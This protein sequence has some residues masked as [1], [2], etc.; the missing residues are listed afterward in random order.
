MKN[1]DPSIFNT[2]DRSLYRIGTDNKYLSENSPLDP[3][4]M[5]SGVFTGEIAQVVG[6]LRSGKEDFSN[7]DIG[8]ILGVEDGIPKFY[9]G[10]ST[11]YLNFDGSTTTIVGGLSVDS[12]DI[13]DTT[14][15]NSFH[16]D[17]SGNAW[18]G[19]NTATTYTGANAYVLSTGA[20]VFKNIQI[21]GSNLQYQVGNGG[22]F[23]FGDGS[24]G[25]VTFSD[26]GTAPSGSTKTDNTAGATVYQLSR[27]VYYETMT[28]NTTVTVNP[29]GYRIFCRTAL[30]NNGTIARNGNNGE[31]YDITNHTQDGGDGATALADGYL[32]GSAAGG[33]GGSGG[34]DG[35]VGIAGSAGSNV[36]NCIGTSNGATGGTGG[37]EGDGTFAG[38]AG[39]TGGTTTASNVKLIAN[40]HLATLLDISSSGSSVKFTTSGTAGGGGGGGGGITGGGRPGGG[41]GG[42]GGNGGIIAIYSKALT[43]G[44]GSFIKANGG[45]GGNG[46][47]GGSGT[48]VV[49]G[50]GGGGAGGNGGVIVLVYNSIS[51]AGTIQSSGGTAG[52]G[53]DGGDSSDGDPDDGDPGSPGSAGNGGAQYLFELSL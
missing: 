7:T 40:W 53:G 44:S 3:A 45:A 10:N 12:L 51:N 21:G 43:L 6:N 1:V 23:T 38:G 17:I 34:G 9:L 46:A 47:K 22:I 35:A 48:G 33:A 28:I 14:T 2:F 27:D 25:T 5:G 36:V 37:T 42:G 41:G 4:N 26:Q 15:A 32:K 52:L 13:P 8:Y 29:N 11:N 20:A 31:S 50:G 39:G 19:A 18:W 49:G 24:D 30:V 16:V